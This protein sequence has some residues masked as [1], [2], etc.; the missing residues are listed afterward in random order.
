MRKCKFNRQDCPVLRGMEIYFKGEDEEY[1]HKTLRKLVIKFFQIGSRI[2]NYI[3]KHKQ[4]GEEMIN[5]TKIER[6]NK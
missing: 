4:K 1:Y 6:R 2:L 3:E 5:K